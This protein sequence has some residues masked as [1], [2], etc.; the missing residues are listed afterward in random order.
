MDWSSCADVERNPAKVSGAW[1]IRGTRIQADAVIANA[2]HGFTA[3]EIAAEIFAGLP[4]DRARR[5][6]AYARAQGAHV[7]D[8][9]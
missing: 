7:A 8:P 2:E 1:V 4:V 6:I 3:E 9:V 5:V